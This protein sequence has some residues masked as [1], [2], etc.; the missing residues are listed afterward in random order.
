MS[1]CQSFALRVAYVRHCARYMGYR[2]GRERASAHS[3]LG[4]RWGRPVGQGAVLRVAVGRRVQGAAVPGGP[5]PPFP[6]L[7][8]LCASAGDCLSFS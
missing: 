5:P 1:V 2:N 3:E 7:F 8:P 4:V 6:L